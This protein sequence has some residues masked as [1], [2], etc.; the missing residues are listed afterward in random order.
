MPRK[1]PWLAWS[2]L[3]CA[4]ALGPA[5]AAGP[6]NVAVDARVVHQTW[7]GFG[8]THESLVYGGTGDVLSA[9]QRQRA[10]D[11]LFAQVKI[12]TGQ[13]PTTFEAPRSSTLAN[14]FG[15]GANDNADP[16]VIDPNGFFTGLGDAFKSKVVDV[17][18][19]PFDLYP[20]VMISTKYANK[21]LASL[22]QSSYDAFLNEC[23][24]QALAG[25]Q[26]WQKTYGAIPAFAML[27]NEPLSG[28]GELAGGNVA[29][30]VDIVKRT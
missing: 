25:V 27:F 17:G 23:A 18:G 19:S 1:W 15:A 28:N 8:A 21:W 3:L 20:D 30:V 22:E 29:A 12:S 10:V 14:F 4:T 16:L 13:A 5:H 24:E 6:V 7:Q 9:S 26:Y 11:A 2:V